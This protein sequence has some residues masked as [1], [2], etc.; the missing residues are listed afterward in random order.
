MGPF[1]HGAVVPLSLIPALDRT[2]S[3]STRMHHILL[4]QSKIT[5]YCNQNKIKSEHVPLTQFPFLKLIKNC[6]SLSQLQHPETT[7]DK[8]ESKLK[9]NGNMLTITKKSRFF[10]IMSRGNVY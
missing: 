7:S 1:G 5:S 10:L 9:H 6:S 3:H 8:E 4:L 2:L